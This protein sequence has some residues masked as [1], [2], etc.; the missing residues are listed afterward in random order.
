MDEDFERLYSVADSA[1][2][3]GLEPLL[4][5]R[6]EW[7]KERMGN[8]DPTSQA[9]ADH[10]AGLAET[11]A[12]ALWA[13]AHRGDVTEE[14]A[15]E[16]REMLDRLVATDAEVTSDMTK[17]SEQAY[18]ALFAYLVE[19]ERRRRAIFAILRDR[20]LLPEPPY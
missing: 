9:L 12:E 4:R 16:F 3:V 14:L 13:L 6:S 11:R 7:V 1:T 8:M 2:L 10:S 5:Q 17:S 19:L 20:N 15:T 18:S